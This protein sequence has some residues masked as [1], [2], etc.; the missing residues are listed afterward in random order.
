[1]VLKIQQF[2]PYLCF[3][4]FVPGPRYPAHQ[5]LKTFEIHRHLDVLPSLSVDVL[6]S[7]VCDWGLRQVRLG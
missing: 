1:M 6:L 5:V 7:V 2:Q 4:P 3:G